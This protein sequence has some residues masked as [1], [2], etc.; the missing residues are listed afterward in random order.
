METFSRV[1]RVNPCEINYLRVTLESYDGMVVV[2]TIDPQ[3]ALIELQI[4]PGCEDLVLEV[5]EHLGKAEN[6][7]IHSTR[8]RHG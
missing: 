5:I 2:R 6:I 3:K 1:F 8:D 4:A 7:S